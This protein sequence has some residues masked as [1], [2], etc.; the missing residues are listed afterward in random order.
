VDNGKKPC[1]EQ[2]MAPR[3]CKWT[4]DVFDAFKQSLQESVPYGELRSR[5]L[6]RIQFLD[7]AKPVDKEREENSV[8]V[9]HEL[10]RA[11]PSKAEFLSA[12]AEQLRS[13]ACG[14]A[15]S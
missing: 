11:S 6:K 3:D 5:A 9:W 12:R 10:E 8:E 1:V 13:I 2:T 7:P 4:A 14:D 15:G